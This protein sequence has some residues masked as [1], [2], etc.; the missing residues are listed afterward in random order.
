[1]AGY[2][3]TN[4]DIKDIEELLKITQ[5]IKY[6]YDKLILLE[7]G[8]R[9]YTD[10]YKKVL[11]ELRTALSIENKL[12]LKIGDNP[13]KLSELLFKLFDC[14][15][16]N[17]VD[18]FNYARDNNVQELIKSRIGFRLEKTVTDA[19]FIEDEEVEEELSCLDY[20]AVEV[21]S[22]DEDEISPIMDME[23]V[24][25][26]FRYM[27][28]LED[29]AELDV[30]NTILAILNKYINDSNYQTIRLFLI[31]FKYMLSFAFQKIEQDLLENNFEI[32]PDLYWGA[33]LVVDVHNGNINDLKKSNE[34]F[35]E[36]IIYE[37]S[38]NLTRLIFEDLSN[39]TNFGSAVISEIIIRASL[40]FSTDET[41]KNFRNFI[42]CEL[43]DSEED[44]K[45][46]ESVVSR[47]VNSVDEDKTLPRIVSFKL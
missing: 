42:L 28:S 46:I 12:Y 25:K 29:Y 14:E 9:K 40:L 34:G 23:D 17:A 19:D 5:R 36:D 4:E 35:S 30:L 22:S 43:K 6:L 39:I 27:S 16:P 8:L 7:C 2:K 11:D 1:M 44:N 10:E 20:D 37:Q 31:R 47:A 45:I 18:T 21:L 24:E 26:Q 41:I 15:Q 13:V 32:N 3:L 33:K 38:D